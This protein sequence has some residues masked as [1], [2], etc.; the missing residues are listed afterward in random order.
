M[1]RLGSG[2][3]LV[4]FFLRA[5]GLHAVTYR[6]VLAEALRYSPRL[7][8]L[9]E[10]IYIRD[11]LYHRSLSSFWPSLSLNARMERFENLLPSSGV[12]TAGGEV[13][14]GQPDEWR[15]SFYLSAE[16]RLSSFYK[17]WPEKEYYRHLREEA[18]CR[19]EAEVRRLLRRVTRAYG[20]VVETRI[21]LEYAEKILARLKEIARLEEE[22]Y[23]KGELAREEVIRTRAEIEAHLRETERLRSELAR[24][25]STLSR[26][27]GKSFGP[28][29]DFESLRPEMEPKGKPAPELS[30]EY[31]AERARL[32]ALRESRKAAERERLPDLTAYA[33]YDLY[34]A[35]TRSMGEALDETRATAFTFGVF[36][37]LPL[38]DGGYRKWERVRAFHELKRQREALRLAELEKT[39]EIRDLR[40][41]YES[42]RRSLRSYENLLQHYRKLHRIA[43]SARKLGGGSEIDVLRLERDLLSVERDLRVTRNTLALLEKLLLLETDPGGLV[44]VPHGK[45]TCKP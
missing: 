6:E 43:V 20:A 34:G 40:L 27:T 14:G 39:R 45:W 31:L 25:L 10:E 17:N 28:E 9:R 12:V 30:P 18:A 32:L 4:A 29:E 16:Y 22:L 21:K 5:W 8:M 37:S 11:A 33:R 26:Y 36:L 7:R 19:H 13:I 35:S 44:D 38:F 41:R 2:I 23:R 42:T 24:E 3:L 15:N 1:C